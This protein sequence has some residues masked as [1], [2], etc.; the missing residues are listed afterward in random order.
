MARCLILQR[1]FLF[2]ACG[3]LVIA[4]AACFE[5]QANSAGEI[6][7]PP[8]DQ[9]TASGVVALFKQ[10]A[11][12]SDASR[13]SSFLCSQ[14]GV[15][16]NAYEQYNSDDETVRY[17]NRIHD[18]EMHIWHVRGGLI[19]RDSVDT[20]NAEFDWLFMWNFIARKNGDKWYIA[21][22]QE[23]SSK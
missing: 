3:M 20:V 14:S 8:P 4:I 18:R 7:I 22:I 6:V 12:S 2:F 21:E 1:F 5:Y 15:P 13:G 16:Y 17:L 19:A 23:E 9:T 11:D 10:A